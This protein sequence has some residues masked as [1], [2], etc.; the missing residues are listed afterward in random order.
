M[1]SRETAYL[2]L[3]NFLKDG[4][5]VAETIEKWR[6]SD[7]PSSADLHLAQEIAYGSVR[8]SLALDEL[9]RQASSKK[10]LN[11]KLKEKALVRTAVYQLWS[12]DRLPAYAVINESLKIARKYCHHHFVAFLNALLRNFASLPK[13]LPQ[14]N[15]IHD[16]STRYSYPQR[17]IQ[18]LQSNYPE[19]AVLQILEA[20]NTPSQTMVRMR[21][22][23][24][25]LVQDALSDHF[26]I[27]FDKPPLLVGRLLD[28]SLMDAIVK[29]S[30]YYIQNITPVDLV[31]S[32]SQHTPAPHHVLDLCASP[33]GKLIA[34]HDIFPNAELHANDVSA[35]KLVKLN[36]NLDKYKIK[37]TLSC[38]NGEEFSPAQRF[39]LVILD[40][41]CSN[42]GVLNKRPE[43]RWR[44][45][46]FC[47]SSPNE[48]DL[49]LIINKQLALIKHALTLLKPGGCIW[50]LT[51]SILKSENEQVVEHACREWGM[52]ASCM[53]TILPNKQGW[54]GGFGC[55]LKQSG[56]N[57]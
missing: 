8:M 17:F 37:A 42:S 47:N 50:Y 18:E 1:N 31:S 54:D 26:E 53:Q 28:T 32:L 34:V 38:S 52:T 19:D 9:A 4:S 55:I 11:L 23:E 43:A 13:T 22:N 41:P 51:C 40:V 7:K 5:F 45:K 57:E 36:F 56:Y 3:L 20:G 33:G 15:S 21:L 25:A 35:G 44:F 29:S 27:T 46:E 12:M 10:S 14:G 48:D 49:A 30:A 6:N 2:A 16:L 39:D 24:T